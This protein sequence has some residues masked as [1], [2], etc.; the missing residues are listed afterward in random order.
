[1]KHDAVQEYYGRTLQGSGDLQT[2]A[3]CTPGEMPERVKRAL[4]NVHDEVMARYYGCGLVMPH[5]LE[6][7]RVLD[8]GCGSGRDV[9][10]LAQMAGPEGSVVGVDM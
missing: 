2:D 10:A 9:Y 7:A 4:S 8:L 1:M 6:G 5:V 3:C